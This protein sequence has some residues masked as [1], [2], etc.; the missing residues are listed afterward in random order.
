MASIPGVRVTDHLVKDAA[1]REAIAITRTE[2]GLHEQREILLDPHDFGY[3]G[4]RFVVAEDYEYALSDGEVKLQTL[5][6]KAGQILTSEARIR[7]AVVD[8]RGEK[9]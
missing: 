6:F 9:P 1:G 2:D 4:L 3:A 5:A 8:S 7:A